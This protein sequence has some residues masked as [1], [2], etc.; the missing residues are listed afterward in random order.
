MLA[1]FLFGV[2]P[3]DTA[4]FVSVPAVLGLVALGACVIPRAGQRGWIR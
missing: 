2:A 3:T 4:V 1:G